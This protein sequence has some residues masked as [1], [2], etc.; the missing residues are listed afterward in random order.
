MKS[1]LS[2]NIFIGLFSGIFAG[3]LLGEY[4]IPLGYIGDAFIGLM[5]M[6]VMPFIMISLLSNLGKVDLTQQKKMLS[7][8]AVVLI[9][10]LGIGLSTLVV[11]PLF[12]PVWESSSF[13]SSHLIAE[14]TTID[15]IKIYIPSNLF[16]ALSS[17]TVPAVVLFSIIVGMALNSIPNNK[18]LIAAFDIITDALN[19]A[20]KYVVK[21]TPYGI[22]G[23][24]AHTTA[25]LSLGELGLIQVYIVI[26]TVAVIMLGFVLLP[27]IVSAVTPF[28][29]KDILNIPRSSLVTIFATG[30]I[31]ILLPQ[32]IE[33]IKQLFEKYGHR[34]E[35]VDSSAEL[36]MPL[37]YPFPNL[38]TL[39]IMIF[40]PF[41]AWFAGQEM[42][43]SDHSVFLGSVLMSSFVAPIAGIPFLMDMLHLPR[44]I[45]QLFIVST[46]FTDRVRV[47]LGAIHLFTLAIIAIA[48][49]KGLVKISYIKL[50]R[51][52]GLTAILAVSILLPIKMLIGDSFQES[53]DKY[54]SF[55]KMDLHIKRAPE[56]TTDTLLRYVPHSIQAIKEVGTIRIGYVSD[57]LPY[58][59]HNDK[60]KKV[61]FDVEMMHIFAN[62]V[63]LNIQWI[64][65]PRSKIDEYVNNGLVDVFVSGMPVLADMM[66]H[67][68]YTVP[69]SEMNIGI[70]V[71]DFDRNRFKSKDKIMNDE[72]AVF[73]T[74]QSNYLTRR[75]KEELPNIRTKKIFSP[76]PFFKDKVDADA[77]FFSVEAGSAWTLIY[78]NYSIVKPEGLNIKLPVSMMVAKNNTDLR[79]YLDNW[80]S[81]KEYDGTLERLYNSWILGQASIKK[82]EHWSI[83]K[84]V[85]HWVE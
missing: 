44:D 59:F 85:F 16:G 52:F 4:A 21:L 25:S 45:F 31:I 8:A 60:A 66:D 74:N 78:P 26:Y 27:L 5:Q 1:K 61:G 57:A 67:V 34:D 65:V 30:K 24:A 73:A 64:E 7:A 77:L 49:A 76:R 15:F 43:V 72:L 62:E 50:L 82:E 63:G 35:E 19:K 17:N 83:I 53:F 46:A 6:T 51:A 84:D 14:P 41:A 39:V 79:R 37:V 55:V 68:E 40:V 18:K 70:L 32:L 12:F 36:L 23:I 38:G 29:F 69:Y 20:N 11:L 3:I 42:S 75:I 48:Y 71:K 80:I 9:V 10:F 56:Q 58:I 22:F 54:E 33:N 81:L 2:R 13:F 28:R 47:V